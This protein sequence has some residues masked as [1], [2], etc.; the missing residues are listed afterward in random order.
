MSPLDQFAAFLAAFAHILSQPSN[1]AVLIGSSLLGIVFGALP[2]LTATLGVGLL[3]TFT[4]GFDLEEAFHEPRLDIS[5]VSPIVIDRRMPQKVIDKI[6]FG[7][8]QLL[9]P[10]EYKLAAHTN[11]RGIWTGPAA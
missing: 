1:W 11:E 9:P 7:S 5:N 6:Q 3:A 4:Y 8:C 10:A 2:G